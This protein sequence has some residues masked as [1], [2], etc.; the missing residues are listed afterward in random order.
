MST[1]GIYAALPKGHELQ[2]KRGIA[3]SFGNLGNA[4]KEIVR[5]ML[6]EDRTA[7]AAKRIAETQDYYDR[8]LRIA[9]KIRRRNEVA[10]AQWGIA[11]VYELYAD[12]PDL[13]NGAGD[14]SILL[15]TA[16]RFAEE[17]HLRYTFLG[18]AKDI[19]ATERLVDQIKSKIFLF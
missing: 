6:A 18:G 1:F 9:E 17:S 14:S 2:D 16:L 19:K 12:Y 13:H 10:H 8:S 5:F 11:E 3:K 15:K 4:T 7:E